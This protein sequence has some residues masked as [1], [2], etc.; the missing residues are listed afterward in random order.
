VNNLIGQGTR[1]NVQADVIV[2]H[3]HAGDP[4]VNQDSDAAVSGDNVAV[5]R[6]CHSISWEEIGTGDE[7]AG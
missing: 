6:D 7:V 5:K 4:T 3:L 2:L 1:V